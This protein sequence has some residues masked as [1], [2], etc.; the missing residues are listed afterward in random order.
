MKVETDFIARIAARPIWW[1]LILVVMYVE[2]FK[3]GVIVFICN[4][5]MYLVSESVCW[6]WQYSSALSKEKCI[7]LPI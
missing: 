2:T 7:Y 5:I 6:Y 1:T 3:I 4:F